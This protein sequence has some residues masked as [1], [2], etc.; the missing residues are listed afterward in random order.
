MDQSGQHA[1]PD[2]VGCCQPEVLFLSEQNRFPTGPSPYLVGFS[3]YEAAI[4]RFW[5]RRPLNSNAFGKTIS[6]EQPRGGARLSRSTLVCSVAC[7]YVHPATCHGRR[8][9]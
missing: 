9:G 5:T 8:G 2:H 7:K 1:F 6:T 4:T 3:F